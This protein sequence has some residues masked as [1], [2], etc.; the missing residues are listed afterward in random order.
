MGGPRRKLLKPAAV[1][2]GL[3]MAVAAGYALRRKQ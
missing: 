2:A 1:A 3:G